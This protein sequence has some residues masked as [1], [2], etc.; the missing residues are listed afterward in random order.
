MI[1]AIVFWK[2]LLIYLAVI[3]GALGILSAFAALFDAFPELDTTVWNFVL[4]IWAGMLWLVSFVLAH[5][6]A[7]GVGVAVILALESL[8]I[9][10]R[11]L[12][13][14]ADALERKR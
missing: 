5:W 11:A 6:I 7:I 12:H 10:A 3:A 4:A 1:I 9:I 14:I 2:P 8:S 13:R